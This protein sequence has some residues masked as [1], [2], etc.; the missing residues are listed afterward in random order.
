[1]SLLIFKILPPSATFHGVDYNERKCK[2]EKASILH[3]EGFGFLMES[4]NKI[5][6]R[7]AKRYLEIHSANNSR[8]RN[9]Q[10]HAVL[11]CKGK[12][13]SPD[14]L[15]SYGLEIVHRLGYA[16]NPILVYGHNDTDNNHIHIISSRVDRDGR[17]IAHHFERKRAN[18]ILTD[19][20][21]IDKEKQFNVDIEQ[22]LAYRYETTAQFKLLLE[23]K[24][25]TVKDGG[26][27]LVLYKYG[28]RSGSVP[29]DTI[30]KALFKPQPDDPGI[31]KIRALIWKYKK[32]HS[33]LPNATDPKYTTAIPQF[34]TPLNNFLH[35]R[36]GL[37]FVFFKNKDHETPYGYAI[38]DHKNKIC[39]K[40]SSIQKLD[41][42]LNSEAQASE[43]REAISELT[44]HPEN[45]IAQ[46]KQLSIEYAEN[47]HEM[48]THERNT[49]PIEQIINDTERAVNEELSGAGKNSRKRKRNRFL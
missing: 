23:Q 12:S 28:N 22:C 30:N 9:K 13:I 49:S 19:I 46:A 41:L 18:E 44:K 3:H 4:A 45:N 31:K 7:Q 34:T 11:S 40:G 6:R 21:G 37:Q 17:K 42:L 25:Y 2:K 20:I 24:G 16:G 48:E 1:M 38:I 47:Q 26:S 10:F 14:R 8:I 27:E 5:D 29:A 36:F 33:V 15:K 32:E 43:Q 39:Y 35:Q